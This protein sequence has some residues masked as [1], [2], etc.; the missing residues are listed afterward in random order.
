MRIDSLNTGYTGIGELLKDREIKNMQLSPMINDNQSIK[1][2]TDGIDID[3][4]EM[5]KQG[6]DKINSPQKELDQKITAFLRGEE[7]LHN[8]M[9]AAENARFTMN[10]TVKV[11]DKI[12]E[13]YQTIMR[14]QV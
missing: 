5:I 10:F 6:I 9:L 12:I 3:L 4:E 8:V 2:S 7:E 1:T 11:R 14:M 13:A